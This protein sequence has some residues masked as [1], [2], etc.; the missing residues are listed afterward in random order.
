[1]L[2]TYLPLKTLQRSEAI[3]YLFWNGHYYYKIEIAIEHASTESLSARLC[4]SGQKV[5]MNA[6]SSID[7]LIFNDEI[8][9]FFNSLLF[10]TS[11]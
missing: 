5:R 3:L 2:Y 6:D 8:D 1:M 4:S 9:Y 11:L 10:N 7:A